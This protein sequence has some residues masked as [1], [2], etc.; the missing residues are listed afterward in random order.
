MDGKPTTD[1][2]SRLSALKAIG[3]RKSYRMD[4]QLR[5]ILALAVDGADALHSPGP[6]QPGLAWAGVPSGLR[7]FCRHMMIWRSR[8]FDANQVSKPH[9]ATTRRKFSPIRD[10]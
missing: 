1:S 8:G 4:G 10:I 7:Q 3:L 9:I 6:G 5:Q 2:G